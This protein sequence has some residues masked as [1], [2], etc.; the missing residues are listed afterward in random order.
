MDPSDVGYPD[1]W[2]IQVRCGRRIGEVVK[3]RFDCVGEHLGRTW[4]WVDMTKV[5]KLDYAIQIPRDVYDVVRARQA[6]TLERFGRRHGVEPTAKQRR[7]IALFP[8]PLANPTFERSIAPSRFGL[9]F[10][11][12][13]ASEQVNLPGHT[14]HQARHT[15]ATRLVSAGASMAHVKRVLGHV[16]EHMSESYVLIAGSQVEPFLQQ[17]WVTGPGNPSRDGSCSPRA[18]PNG[19]WH[20]I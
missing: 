3:L 16:S 6:K 12:W 15:L 9:K 11:E 8:S 13:I 7:A 1:I 10:R 19:R 14:T 20:R 5:G 2:S 4:L 18:T 17:V